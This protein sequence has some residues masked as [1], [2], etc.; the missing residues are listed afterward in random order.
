[1]NKDI[2]RMGMAE[3]VRDFRIDEEDGMGVDPRLENKMVNREK[4][5]VADQ[6]R[7]LG[8]LKN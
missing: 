1:M 5:A 4:M 7:T 3:L 8:S 6:L 2:P